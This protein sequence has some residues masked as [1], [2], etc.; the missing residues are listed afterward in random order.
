MISRVIIRPEAK[1]DLRE[2]RAWYRNVS[3]ELGKDFVRRTEDAIALA[4]ERPLAFQ[5]VHRTFRRVLLHR[6][7]YA[8]FYHAGENGIVVVAVLHQARDP[9]I[10]ESRHA[11]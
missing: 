2:A 9:E 7:P 3:P 1:D 10:L 11:Q 5:I 4:R 6:F 8:L